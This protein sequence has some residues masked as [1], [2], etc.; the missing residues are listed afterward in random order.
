MDERLLLTPPEAAMALAISE[1][2]LWTLTH[3]RGPIPAVRI[4]RTVRYDPAD[5]RIW[6]EQQKT[7]ND[8]GRPEQDGR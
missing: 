1:R 4:G 7:P 3:P 6:I 8:N 5:L 2:S